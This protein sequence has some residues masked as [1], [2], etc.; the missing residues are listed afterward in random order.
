MKSVTLKWLMSR[1]T[2]VVYPCHLGAYLTILILKSFLVG[3]QQL[4]DLLLHQQL[5]E[6]LHDKPIEQNRKCREIKE[7]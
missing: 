4:T 7:S 5:L 6:M 3:I 1:E 2:F